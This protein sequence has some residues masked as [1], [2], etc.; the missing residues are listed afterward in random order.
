[1]KIRHSRWPHPFQNPPPQIS[2]LSYPDRHTTFLSFLMMIFAKGVTFIF[3]EFCADSVKTCCWTDEMTRLRQKKSFRR[4]QPGTSK[5]RINAPWISA[6]FI[7]AS[8]TPAG[9]GAYKYNRIRPEPGIYHVE[10]GPVFFWVPCF[11]Y[12]WDF[13]EISLHVFSRKNIRKHSWTLIK[14]P[15]SFCHFLS[16][17]FFIWTKRKITVGVSHSIFS[18]TFLRFLW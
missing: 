4:W 2:F 1:M 8:T 3:G 6:S 5:M 17:I 15:L 7:L 12:A 9:T 14:K 13:S 18:L 10:L 16:H 11:F